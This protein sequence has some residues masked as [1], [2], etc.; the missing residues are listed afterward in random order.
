MSSDQN[1]LALPRKI[2]LQSM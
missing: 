2:G 1:N